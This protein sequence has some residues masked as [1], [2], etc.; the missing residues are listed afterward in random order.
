MHLDI[1][2]VFTVSV[3]V[4]PISLQDDAKL[5]AENGG[6]GYFFGLQ[7]LSV[8]KTYPSDTLYCMEVTIG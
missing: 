2:H 4:G 7:A 5:Q 8:T 6:A 1:L 3:Q